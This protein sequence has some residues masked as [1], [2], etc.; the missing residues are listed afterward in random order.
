MRRACNTRLR[1]VLYHW[2]RVSVQ[3]DRHSKARYTSLRRKGHSHARDL[4]SLADRLLAQLMAM[5][6]NGSPYQP[7]R[8][9]RVPAG[10]VSA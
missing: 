10:A 6:R 1:N 7:D 9:R 4:R 2:A 3:R 8:A 5:L